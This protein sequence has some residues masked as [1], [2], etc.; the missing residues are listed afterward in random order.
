MVDEQEEHFCMSLSLALEHEDGTC[1]FPWK[2]AE[3]IEASRGV[4]CVIHL[5]P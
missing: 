4:S 3:R 1:L 5:E 2:A